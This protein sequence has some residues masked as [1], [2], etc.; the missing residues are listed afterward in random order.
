MSYCWLLLIKSYLVC[1]SIYMYISHITLMDLVGP[2]VLS[3][4]LSCV[5]I[6]CFLYAS[7][8]S[9]LSTSISELSLQ[10]VAQCP[11]AST[12]ELMGELLTS[13]V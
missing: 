8:I 2:Y 1:H 6:S 13:Y 7:A 12:L 10:T 9:R 3:V 11:S 5:N 4:F